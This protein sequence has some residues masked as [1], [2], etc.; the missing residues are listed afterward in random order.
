MT[1]LCRLGIQTVADAE[2][3]KG[4]VAY[5]QG[6]IQKYGLNAPSMNCGIQTVNEAIKENVFPISMEIVF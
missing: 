1:A 3:C 2:R 5:H 6:S 4:K